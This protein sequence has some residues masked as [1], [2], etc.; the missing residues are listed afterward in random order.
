MPTDPR[1]DAYIDRQADFAKPILRHIRARMHAVCPDVVE[2]VKWSRPFFDYKGS[3][4][5]IMSGF[6]AHASFGFWRRDALATGQEGEAMGQFGRLTSVADLP[7]NAEFDALIR[8]AAALVDAGEGAIKRK[9]KPGRPEL[10]VPLGQ[11]QEML[12]DARGAQLFYY[13]DMDSGE[14]S[15]NYLDRHVVD[16]TGDPHQRLAD[17]R[18]REAIVT[19]I[20]R[21]PEREKLVMGLYYEQEMNL[22]E[23]G[24]VMGVTESRVSQLHSQAIARMRA[25]LREKAWTGVA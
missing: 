7:G 24:A 2:T 25:N 3:P 23:I 15:D 1:I 21:L 10:E 9:A 14:D 4:L 12:A 13:E 17:R 6:K 18:F 22:K 8:E 5:A 19:G 20:D 11:Y 16:R